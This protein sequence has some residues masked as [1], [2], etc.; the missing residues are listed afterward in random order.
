MTVIFNSEGMACS[1]SILSFW[2]IHF[3]GFHQSYAMALQL[4]AAEVY[5]E[6]TMKLKWLLD[7]LKRFGL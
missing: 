4:M 3:R 5:Y 6:K 7:L 1:C 2:L